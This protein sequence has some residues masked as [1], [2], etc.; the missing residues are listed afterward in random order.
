LWNKIPNPFPQVIR[1]FPCFDT[2]S[3]YPFHTF[4][5]ALPYSRISSK[6]LQD[7]EITYVMRVQRGFNSRIDKMKKGDRPV[8]LSDGN[9]IRAVVFWLANG[10]REALITNVGKEE[11][12]ASVTRDG[13]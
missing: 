4:L 13:R 2:A 3:L 1:Q 7:K 9:T 10:G 5:S 6:Y 8:T 11:M 12:D